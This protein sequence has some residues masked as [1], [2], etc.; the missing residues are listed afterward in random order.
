MAKRERN[1]DLPAA[2]VG[3]SG[4]HEPLG[5]ADRALKDPAILEVKDR[6]SSSPRPRKRRR[7]ARASGSDPQWTRPKTERGLHLREVFDRP[8][9]S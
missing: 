5:R 4:K 2:V 7:A 9:L 3:P 6:A 8:T 1:V